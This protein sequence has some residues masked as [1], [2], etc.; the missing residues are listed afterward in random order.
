MHRLALLLLICT[1]VLSI[2]GQT[3]SP[4]YE[5]GTIMAVTAHQNASG[6]P[7]SD[8]RRYDVSVKIGNVLYV[9]LFS[10]PNGVSS[11]EYAPGIDMLFSVGSTTLTFNSKVSGAT[12]APILRREILSTQNTLNGAKARGQY[13]SMK[14]QHLSEVLNLTDE[15]QAKIKPLLE[16]ETAEAGEVLWN[17]VLS[18]KDRLKRYEKVVSSSDVKI[19]AFLSPTQ[20]DK[21]EELRKEQRDKVKR[22]ILEQR[23]EGDN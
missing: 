15:Q 4:K 14:Q 18:P 22:A 20:I 16:H 19:K 8:V 13:F 17:P 7:A 21:L 3:T 12:E 2:F 6:E 11:V 5:R 1:Y 9:V 23:S 10:P